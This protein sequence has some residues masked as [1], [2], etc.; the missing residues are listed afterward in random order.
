MLA[1]HLGDGICIGNI[2][3]FKKLIRRVLAMLS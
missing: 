2:E 1:V 3:N